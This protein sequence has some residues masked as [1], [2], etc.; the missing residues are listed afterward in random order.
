MKAIPETKR[1]GVA[2]DR[3]L[4]AFTKVSVLKMKLID[5]YRCGFSHCLCVELTHFL[6]RLLF[7]LPLVT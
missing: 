1:K 2:L 3:G 6:Y 4:L 5:N 7:N